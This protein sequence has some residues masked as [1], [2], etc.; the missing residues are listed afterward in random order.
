[1]FSSP[2]YINYSGIQKM[3]PIKLKRIKEKNIYFPQS[4]TRSI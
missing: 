1:M 3:P 4:K 2:R